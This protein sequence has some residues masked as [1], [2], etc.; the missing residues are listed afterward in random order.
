MYHSQTSTFENRGKDAEE[1]INFMSYSHLELLGIAVRRDREALGIT[2]DQVDSRAKSHAKEFGVYLTVKWCGHIE[3]CVARDVSPAERML[4]ASCLKQPQNRYL[5]LPTDPRK[6]I[7]VLLA[8]ETKEN[9]ASML[10]RSIVFPPEYKQ[11]GVA[12]LSYFSEIVAKKYPNEDVQVSILQNGNSVT[13]RVETSE[14][15][16]EQ[17]EKTLEQYGLVVTGKL[18]LNA[19]TTDRE[20]IRDLK[21]RLEV[22]SLELRLRQESYLEQKSNY[23]KRVGSLEEQVQNLFAVVS[24]G[25]QHANTLSGVISHL[26]STTKLNERIIVSL[27]RISEL[28]TQAH[29]KEHE[30]ALAEAFAQVQHESPS[31]Y[32]QI[33]ATLG[34]IP[35]GIMAN[36]ATPWVQAV[37]NGLPK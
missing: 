18:P 37:I 7:G 14:G 29:S 16:I 11:A 12:I 4:L 8:R 2:Q 21:T 10:E 34:S 5:N 26:A 32:Q 19:F 20:L 22:T 17:I 30:Q 9:K 23:D 24:T 25:L 33:R 35:A 31:F 15:K 3:R 1:E 13:L 6:V 36:L 28:A 27:D